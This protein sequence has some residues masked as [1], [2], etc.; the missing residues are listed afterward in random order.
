MKAR[1]THA[2]HVSDIHKA[3]RIWLHLGGQIEPVRRTG[4][5]RYS[6]AL[7]A[8]PVRTNGRRNDTSAKIMSR[9]NQLVKKQAANDP[10]WD[11]AD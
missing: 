11:V 9:I 5:L 4:E 6:H 3:D 1:I 7:F 10:F 2:V 8:K